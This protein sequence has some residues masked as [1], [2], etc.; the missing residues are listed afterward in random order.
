MG[1][2]ISIVVPAYNVEPY[3]YN[4]LNSIMNQT[5]PEIEILLVDDGST[6]NTLQI[7]NHFQTTFPDK[8][9]VIHTDNQ[10]VTKARFEGIKRAKGEWIGFV[11]GDDEIEPEMYE[12]LYINAKKYDAD[13][14]HCGYKTIVNGGERIHYFYNTGRLIEQDRDSAIKDLLDGPIEP[15]LWNKLFRKSI[16]CS[17]IDCEIMDTSIKYNEDL[18]MNFYLFSRADKSVYE[19]FCGYHYLAHSTSV[20]RNKIRVEKLLDPVKV[21]NQILDCLESKNKDLAWRKFFLVCANAY[22][23]LLDWE[24]YRNVAINCREKLLDNKNKWYLLSR[25]ERI[26]IHLMLFSTNF[27]KRMYRFYEKH[28]QRKVYE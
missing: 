25:K 21:W 12:R 15:G 9:H 8:V 4:C 27:Y 3:L 11:D 28:F 18:L 14:S 24:G 6:D 2:I 23:Y 20:T 19:D 10:G 1:E 17:V 7:A 16:V 22:L 13:I 5:Y 26:K